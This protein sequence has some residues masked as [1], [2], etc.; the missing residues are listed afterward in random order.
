MCG[1]AI[2]D[3]DLGEECDDGNLE[4]NDDCRNDC[5]K[6]RCG[7]GVVHAG[8]E[9]C[10]DQNIDDDDDCLS[11]CVF[12]SCGDGFVQA[13][14]EECDDGNEEDGDACSSDCKAGA[15]C[16]NG[17][18]D[19]GEDCDDGNKSNSDACT[20][21]CRDATCGDGY[22][23]IGFEECDDGNDVDDDSC[24]N[25][26][27]VNTPVDTGCPGTAASVMAN[28]DVT[29]GGDTSTSEDAYIGS[30][31]GDANEVVFAITAQATGLLDV[32]MIAI[33]D[34]LDPVLYVRDNDCEGGSELG[35]ADATFSG[36]YEE[37]SIAATAGHTYY[38]FADGYGGSAGEFLIS[39]TLLAQVPGD[40][41]P[42]LALSLSSGVTK[43]VTGNTA[44]ANPDRVGTGACSSPSTKEI[45]YKVTA[46][47]TGKIFVSV[48][49]AYDASVYIRTACTAPAT[50][51]TCA[52]SAGV[53]GLEVASA[54][55]TAG[56]VYYVFVDGK[57]GSAG[58]YSADFL[59]Q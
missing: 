52:E 14:V 5:T 9:D 45:V 6:A 1:D 19:A 4:D 15:G 40:D 54:N 22:A 35:C 16:G 47:A 59:V 32:E 11:T 44:A 49:P 50:Q 31:G 53:G 43:T 29:L 23:E 13:G 28:G 39:A 58:A 27:T 25:T 20:N 33:N 34:D 41:C 10:D 17:T 18:I 48:D 24:S 37:L 21:D 26:C 51:I 57:N 56:S 3:P 8:Y 46:P 36:G 55:V 7:D 12:A 38:V 30:C 2:P 42:G